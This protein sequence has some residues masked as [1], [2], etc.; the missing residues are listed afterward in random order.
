[1][2]PSQK[3]KDTERQFLCKIVSECLLLEAMSGDFR[4]LGVGTEHVAENPGQQQHPDV[5]SRGIRDV[6]GWGI[7][8]AV[9]SSWLFMLMLYI[10]YLN[11][12]VRNSI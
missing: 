3:K 11:S 7:N 12:P 5:L 2:T 9:N 6:P 8:N 1:M 10:L 4:N